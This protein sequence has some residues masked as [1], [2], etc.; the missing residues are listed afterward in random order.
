[1]LQ[2][3][4][5]A[6]ELKPDLP[7]WTTM[8]K[9]N[10]TVAALLTWLLF[11]GLTAGPGRATFSGNGLDMASPDQEAAPVP[12][13]T[14][15]D[16]T[17][18]VQLKIQ[19]LGARIVA[20]ESMENRQTANRLAASLD[21]LK[22][23]TSFLREIEIIHQ[24]QLAAL[25]K[26]ESLQKELADLQADAGSGTDKTLIRKPPYSLNVY[27]YYLD[28]LADSARRV[29][30]VTQAIAVGKKTLRD[31]TV[32]LNDAEKKLRV[33]AEKNS[34]DG[35]AGEWRKILAEDEKQ[36]ARAL[37]DLQL[38]N[39]E[40]HHLDLNLAELKKTIAQQDIDWL[41]DK[42]VFRAEELAGHLA[43]LEERRKE[44][45][46]RIDKL[47][48]EQNIAENKWLAAQR[49]LEPG[50][51]RSEKQ[52]AIDKAYL[53][54]RENWRETY[55]QVISQ[56]SSMLQLLSGEAQ[57][58]QRRYLFLK[59]ETS[60]LELENW[61][62]EAR[63]EIV[64]RG[65]TIA[66]QQTQQNSVQVKIAALR[67]QLTKENIDPELGRQLDASF[68]ALTKLGERSFE[69]LTVLQSN[70]ELNQ[71]LDT[72]I[73]AHLD[74]FNFGEWLASVMAAGLSIWQY[75]LFAVDTQGVT[76]GKIF[77]VFV[78]LTAGV[79]FAGSFKRWL[80]RQLQ[81]R[82]HLSISATAITEKL[83]YYTT[84]LIVIV[85]VM[86]SVNIPMTTFAF[87]GGAVAI[88]VGF[89]AQ[90]LINNFISGF[91][92]MVEQ[93]IRVG[94]LVQM[95]SNLG[96]IEDIGVRSTR[97]LTFDNAH[98]L[99]PNS[100]FLENN[101]TNWTH[102]D[103]MVRGKVEVGVVYGSSTKQVKKLL[104]EAA[105]AHGEVMKS[106]T[107]FVL[108]DDFGDNALVFSLYLW[109]MVAR[110]IDKRRIESDVRFIVE[111]LF[112]EGG[113][114]IAFPQRDVHLDTSRPLRI[115]ITKEEKG[116]ARH[117]AGQEIGPA[118]ADSKEAP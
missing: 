59:G 72:A 75:E 48:S 89:G 93:P 47:L 24:R 5:P 42:L 112:H 88:G 38:R 94:D 71:R 116:P 80:H 68:Q 4:Y 12:V 81:L 33:L 105:D 16:R 100:Y 74:G 113:L 62:K 76:V 114:V 84:L 56:N 65:R 60:G 118:R 57:V 97:V 63:A 22:L 32:R 66:L 43:S 64:A 52:L 14:I 20:A 91:I 78:L 18:A 19:A 104:L 55:Q 86:R 26:Q 110:V 109:I 85:I 67:I 31:A 21:D 58:W 30:V 87:M 51:A 117:E 96:M 53:Q 17:A 103:N 102:N 35:A 37:I 7:G 73:D 28:Q 92:L 99:V 44:L 107:P 115:T 34:E 10:Y 95:D 2:N 69:Y 79:I 8:R 36:Y 50:P 1:M 9:Y 49:R 61:R 13:A 108:F 82:L 15:A 98:L 3:I 54:A 45:E 101:I 25:T 40:N 77:I 11:L 23:R 6:P 111:K 46:Q 39:E 90:K 83:I 106:P 29:E 70:I 41:K 27:D